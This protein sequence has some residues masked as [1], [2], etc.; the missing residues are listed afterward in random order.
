MRFK[1]GAAL[2]DVEVLMVTSSGGH[3]LVFPK[4]ISAQTLCAEGMRQP[5]DKWWTSLHDLYIS[6]ELPPLFY[7]PH[8]LCCN[9]FNKILAEGEVTGNTGRV[10][11]R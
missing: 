2:Q 1:E 3:G 6:A 11:D 9:A 8:L 10:G 4:V 7:N 5:C